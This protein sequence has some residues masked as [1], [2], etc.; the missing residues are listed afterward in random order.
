MAIWYSLW[1]F[2]IFSPFW[3][4]CTEKHLAT[5]VLLNSTLATS[6]S[7]SKVNKLVSQ[8]DSTN[9]LKSNF[10][11]QCITNN[12]PPLNHTSDALLWH[13]SQQNCYAHPA[14]KTLPGFEPGSSVL[15]A[16]ATTTEPRQLIACKANASNSII[17]VMYKKSGHAEAARPPLSGSETSHSSFI[18]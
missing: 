18:E 3:Y 5:L 14:Q 13:Y 6:E 12:S 9:I 11:G 15:R 10:S 4:V 16:G 8:R 17:Q 7:R 2:G 1:S